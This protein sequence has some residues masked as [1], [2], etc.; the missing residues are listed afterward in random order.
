MTTTDSSIDP[1]IFKAY[2]VR[3]V[4]GVDLTEDAVYRIGRAAAIYLNVPV[5]AVCRDM[6]ISSPQLTAAAIRGITDQGVNVVD[7]GL[8]TTDELYFIVGYYNFLAGIM[9]TASHNPK[10]YN[11][12]KFCRA[13]AYPISL[14]T[15]LADI[16]DLAIRGDF[17]EPER[18]GSV[19]HLD[20]TDDYIKHALSYIDVSKIRPLKVVVDASNG[21]AGMVMPRVFQYLP[22]H[23]VPLYFELDGTFPNHSPSPIEPENLVAL[24]KKVLEVGADFGAAFDGD[25]DRMFPVD[26]HGQIVDGSMVML[27]VSNSILRKYPGSTILYNL[28]LSKSVPALIERDGGKAIRTRRPFL[29]QSRDAQGQCHLRRRTFRA[30]LLPRQLVRRFGLDRLPA[31]PGTGLGGKQATLRTDQA[32]GYVGT[33]WGDQHPCQRCPGQAESH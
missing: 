26:E 9:I 24:Q 3:G 8:T 23:L 7:C 30:F 27:L 15:G 4:Y 19:T 11:G 5:I 22:A 20:A 2:D 31:H 10:E 25:A 12:M 21:M 13:Q 28:I 18:K 16:R 14:D 33:Q 17:P 29:Y 6:R 32:A 1:T